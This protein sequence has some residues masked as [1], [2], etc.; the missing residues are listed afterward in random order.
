MASRSQDVHAM[1]FQFEEL[2]ALFADHPDLADRRK[3]LMDNV[4]FHALT[5]SGK[6]PICT[7][8]LRYTRNYGSIQ[9]SAGQNI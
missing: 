8:S 4:S 7:C 1:L 5:W 6:C 3:I 2:I 9:T